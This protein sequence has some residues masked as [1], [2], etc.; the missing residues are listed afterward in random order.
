ML[1]GRQKYSGTGT[2]VV[3]LPGVLLIFLIEI[4]RSYIHKMK[5]MYYHVT[6]M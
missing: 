5:A 2:E 4:E 6:G 3:M 1:P